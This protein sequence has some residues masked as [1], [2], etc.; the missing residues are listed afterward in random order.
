MMQVEVE[1]LRYTLTD[2]QETCAQA[3]TSSS[4]R[5]AANGNVSSIEL[6]TIQPPGLWGTLGF[7]LYQPW[8]SLVSGGPL[9]FRWINHFNTLHFVSH[10]L[11]LDFSIYNR[12]VCLLPTTASCFGESSGCE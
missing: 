10:W 11:V 8:P 7:P 5:P 6:P 12:Q 2:L 1:T 3:E 4:G 9:A